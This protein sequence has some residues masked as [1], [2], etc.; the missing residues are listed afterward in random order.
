MALSDRTR[1]DVEAAPWVINDIKKL[2]DALR[3]AYAV[4]SFYADDQTWHCDGKDYSKYLIVDKSDIGYGNYML[5]EDT[6]DTSVG[7]RQAREILEE[8]TELKILFTKLK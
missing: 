2:E 8:L 1:P 3:K 6:D 7:G 4:I 5:N